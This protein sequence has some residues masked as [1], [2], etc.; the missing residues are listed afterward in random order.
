MDFFNDLLTSY[1]LLKKRKL[2][3]TLDEGVSIDT[4]GQG[5]APSYGAIRSRGGENGNTHADEVIRRTDE[6]MAKVFPGVDVAATP[7]PKGEVNDGGNGALITA[8]LEPDMKLIKYGAQD[9]GDTGTESTT[10]GNG[11]KKPAKETP[12]CGKGIVWQTKPNEMVIYRT[13]K[14]GPQPTSTYRTMVA[15]H[16]WRGG[17]NAEDYAENIDPWVMYMQNSREGSHLLSLFK[18]KPEVISQLTA[19]MRKGWVDGKPQ[20]SFYDPEKASSIFGVLAKT[21]RTQGQRH[22]NL[23]TRE[24]PVIL[25]AQADEQHTLGALQTMVKALDVILRKPISPDDAE[26]MKE[27]L[28]FVTDRYGNKQLYFESGDGTGVNY[29][30]AP[31]EYA[32]FLKQFEDYNELVGYEFPDNPEDFQITEVDRKVIYDHSDA[33]VKSQ[34]VITEVSEEI[35][36]VIQ[37]LK[38]RNIKFSDDERAQKSSQLYHA[39]QDTYGDN[40]NKV[41]RAVTNLPEEGVALADDYEALIEAFHTWKNSYHTPEKD[42]AAQRSK[43]AGRTISPQESVDIDTREFFAQIERLVT[44]KVLEADADFIIR[45]GT[46][47]GSFG[48]KSDHLYL[49]RADEMADP[50]I[51]AEPGRGVQIHDPWAEGGNGKDRASKFMGGAAGGF[52]ATPRRF[53][54]IVRNGVPRGKLSQKEWDYKGLVA[55]ERTK[56]L[57][58]IDD[59]ELQ[60]L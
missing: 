36:P 1:A 19:L 27:N 34:K 37:I 58:G 52:D 25:E 12:A 39:L 45:V 5:E 8:P 38:S 43:E 55:W 15:R 44:K 20:D 13:C 6:H 51:T 17:T 42:V 53:Q 3:I 7:K 49:Y 48:F 16:F 2:S 50:K 11:D 30:A 31:G 33:G 40:I 47:G 14:V 41:I 60:V 54:D 46:G 9:Q 28:F 24:A 26:W 10:N 21:M 22:I 23:G 59:D 56:D 29:T 18:D 4:Q 57:W 35:S 32:N